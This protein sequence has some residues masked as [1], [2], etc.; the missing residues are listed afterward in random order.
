MAHGE[1]NNDQSFARGIP[2]AS[3]IICSQRS[4]YGGFPA[5]FRFRPASHSLH[6]AGTDESC[7]SAASNRN[8]I[9][10]VFIEFAARVAGII[11]E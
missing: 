1:R 7:T 10:V 5:G 4:Q 6:F 2:A 8:R 9:F 3:V 11:L